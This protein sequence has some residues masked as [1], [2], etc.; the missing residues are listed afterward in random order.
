MSAVKI[1][2][3]VDY[4]IINLNLS[5]LFRNSKF[6]RKNNSKPVRHP[7]RTTYICCPAGFYQL[8]FI[9]SFAAINSFIWE[10]KI[11]QKACHE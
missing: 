1:L 6:C 11:A 5:N 4:E 9:R 2:Y 7:V 8:I 3:W 10:E